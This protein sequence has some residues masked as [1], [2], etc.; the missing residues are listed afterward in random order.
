MG[1]IILFLLIGTIVLIGYSVYKFPGYQ[2]GNI[3]LHLDELI[4]LKNE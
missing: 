4:S 1:I 2:K 3:V